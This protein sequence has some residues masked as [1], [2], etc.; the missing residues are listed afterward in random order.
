MSGL[1]CTGKH[2]VE[3]AR[4]QNWQV[5]GQEKFWKVE[6]VESVVKLSTERELSRV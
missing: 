4:Y 6:S 1:I 2:E 5:R 3:K